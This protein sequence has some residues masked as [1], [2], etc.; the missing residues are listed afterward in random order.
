LI[1]FDKSGFHV[2]FGPFSEA[3]QIPTKDQ[4]RKSESTFCH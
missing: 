4:N 3:K 2:A 1:S